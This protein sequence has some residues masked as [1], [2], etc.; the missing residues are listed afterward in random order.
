MGSL[1]I[2]LEMDMNSTQCTSVRQPPG[3]ELR[4]SWYKRVRETATCA[5]THKR[6][7]QCAYGGRG[8]WDSCCHDNRWRGRRVEAGGGVISETALLIV[9]LQC[10]ALAT[11]QEASRKSGDSTGIKQLVFVC[12][13]ENKTVLITQ[14]KKKEKRKKRHT[15]NKAPIN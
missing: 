3:P 14:L 13:L 10:T 8:W 6:T 1:A 4:D 2:I 5:R 15:N 12:R 7:R 9:H 11:P